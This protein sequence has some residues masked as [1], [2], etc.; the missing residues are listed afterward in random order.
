MYHIFP[1]R[2]LHIKHIKHIIIHFHISIPCIL[3]KHLNLEIEK[4]IKEFNALF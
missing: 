2:K 3:K 1:R 4:N